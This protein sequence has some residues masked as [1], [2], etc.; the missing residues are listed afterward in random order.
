M[1]YN[2]K[3]A[4]RIRSELGDIPIVEKRMFGGVGF[5]IHGNTPAL[6]PGASVA[7][8][9][10]KENMIVRVDP[11]KHATLLKKPGARPFDITG[12]PMK[13]WLQVEPEGCRISKQLSAWVKE[14]VEFALTL[15][16]K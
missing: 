11:A 6:A 4:G 1:A 3:L 10:H 12:R 16:A 8:G 13:G 9:V 15:P 5:L 2:E 7:C 14:G